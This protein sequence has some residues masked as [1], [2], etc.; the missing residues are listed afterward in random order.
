MDSFEM[1]CKRFVNRKFIRKNIVKLL[2]YNYLTAFCLFLF[3]S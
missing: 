1:C 2:R 3:E